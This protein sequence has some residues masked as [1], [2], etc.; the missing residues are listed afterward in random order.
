MNPKQ[1]K[2]GAGY[3]A[4]ILIVDDTAANLQVLACMLKDRGYKVRPVPDGKL[5]LQAAQRD[6]PD[7]I[8]LDINMPE[9]NGYEVCEHLKADVKL[10]RI[11][12]IFISALNEHFDKLKAFTVG[13]VDYLTKPFQIE[14]LHA[15]VT[16]HLNLH[17]LQTELENSNAHLEA[18]FRDLKELQVNLSERL[19]ELECSAAKIQQLGALLP[20]CAWCRKVRDDHNYWHELEKYF[21]KHFD[22]QITH[23]ICPTCVE[24]ARAE[25]RA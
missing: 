1:S 22:G 19:A 12:V 5:A 13:G 3:V 17:R 2:N 6:P 8:L 18:A 10:K 7:L 16:T 20:M 23:G 11:P 24:K 14:E 25:M 9:M 15:R 4:N 21:T